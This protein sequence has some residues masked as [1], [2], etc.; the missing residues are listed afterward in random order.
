MVV[1]HDFFKEV[2]VAA[3]NIT[4]GIWLWVGNTMEE[5]LKSWWKD[6]KVFKHEAFPFTACW[7]LWLTRHSIIFK[8]VSRCE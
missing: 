1:G 4:R 5:A 2:W 3:K 6:E 8:D 7:V